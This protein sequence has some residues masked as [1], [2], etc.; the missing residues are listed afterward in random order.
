MTDAV[1][2]RHEDHAH[3]RNPRYLSGVVDGAV[4]QIHSREA[5]RL[6]GFANDALDW[7]VARCSRD[8]IDHLATRPQVPFLTRPR[9]PRTIG[10]LCRSNATDRPGYLSRIGLA[11]CAV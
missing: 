11:H 5:G 2:A 9:G 1:T 8:L 3:R 7:L 4:R 10:P 6:R